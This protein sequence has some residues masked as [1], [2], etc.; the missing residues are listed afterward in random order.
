MQHLS[1]TS[2]DEEGLPSPT[3]NHLKT[4]LVNTE[5]EGLP[6]A[7]KESESEGLPVALVNA[8]LVRVKVLVNNFAGSGI[9]PQG[10]TGRNTKRKADKKRCY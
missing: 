2:I 9:E 7:D 10:L 5:S 3:S 1:L 6:G 8:K 4:A